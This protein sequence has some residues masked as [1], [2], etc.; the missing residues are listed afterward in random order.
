MLVDQGFEPDKAHRE[1]TL[2]AANTDTDTTVL[3]CAA[4]LLT[5]F[6]ST[7]RPAV[8]PIE[9]CY[10]SA[11]SIAALRAQGRG[12]LHEAAVKVGPGR[13]GPTSVCSAG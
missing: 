12:R 4:E 1:I 10:P 2:R 5:P 11:A 8:S 13:A 3:M 7:N 9:I 6:T